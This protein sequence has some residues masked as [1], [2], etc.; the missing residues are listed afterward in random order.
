MRER[1][2]GGEEVARPLKEVDLGQ[3]DQPLVRGDGLGQ[4]HGWGLCV[5]GV[6]EHWLGSMRTCDVRTGDAGRLYSRGL[7]RY[8]TRAGRRSYSRLKNLGEHWLGSW[9]CDT[10]TDE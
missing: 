8:L 4:T 5:Q 2:D 1:L 9:I 3:A 10:G 7:A 6:G